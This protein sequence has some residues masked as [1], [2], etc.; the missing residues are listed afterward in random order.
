MWTIFVILAGVSTLNGRMPLTGPERINP[1]INEINRCVPETMQ[2]GIHQAIMHL[3][4]A[5]KIVDELHK[6]VT[7]K[8]SDNCK[9]LAKMLNELDMES[10]LDE[11]NILAK[12]S[13]DDAKVISAL[14]KDENTGF[15]AH[16]HTMKRLDL[17]LAGYISILHHKITEDKLDIISLI[18]S[19]DLVQRSV[20]E[21]IECIQLLSYL[22]VAHNKIDSYAVI[23]EGMRHT[24]L[25]KIVFL[26][27]SLV[28]MTEDL[29]VSYLSLLDKGDCSPDQISH[30]MG[31]NKRK[32]LAIQDEQ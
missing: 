11:E 19:V 8:F 25:F 30:A 23:L 28:T 9:L 29:R 3:P 17:H 15:K 10:L 14:L 21:F 24:L 32:T 16:I 31:I 5:A 12:F 22:K 4:K 1:S 2:E 26:V 18:H 6:V 13:D 27:N 7:G 20:L